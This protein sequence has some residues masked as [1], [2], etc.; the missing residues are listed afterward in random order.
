MTETSFQGSVKGTVIQE[1]VS[2]NEEE[3]RTAQE[4]PT[5]NK[6]T[7]TQAGNMAPKAKTTNM[8]SKMKSAD[9]TTTAQQGRTT[10]KTRQAY[11]VT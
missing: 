4:I 5:V 6:V 7:S 11:M 9:T 3:D 10:S 8:A 2:E 1:S